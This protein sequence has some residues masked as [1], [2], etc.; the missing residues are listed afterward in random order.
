MAVPATHLKKFIQ[1][2]AFVIFIVLMAF[3]LQKYFD[4]PLMSSP[5]FKTLS[6]LK[7]SLAVAVCKTSQFN[8][9]YARELTYMGS[10]T[11]F[12][13]HI[14]NTSYLSWSG[15]DGDM[16]FDEAMGSL[17]NSSLGNV[18]VDLEVGKENV[19]TK[20]LLPHGVCYIVKGNQKKKIIIEIKKKIRL[21]YFGHRPCC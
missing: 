12:R 15:P 19:I 13:G 18:I 20:F 6:T 16:N 9:T 1:T 4:Q 14:S 11:F 17:Y 21:H 5:S 8:Y 3:A 2:V 10:G 7:R